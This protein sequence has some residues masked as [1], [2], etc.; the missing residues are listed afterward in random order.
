MNAPLSRSRVVVITGVTRGLGRALVD[1]FIRLGHRVFG[2]ARTS[3][4]IEALRREYPGHD[5]QSVD[6]SSDILVKNWADRIVSEH[7]PPNI[8]VNNAAVLNHR[9]NLWDIGDRDF[10]EVID[11]NIKG[12]ANTVRYFTPSM[13]SRGQGVIVNLTSRWGNYTERKM[14]P[15]CATKWAVVAISRVLA[16][17]L[18]PSGVA[19]V[20]LNPGV[21]KTAM[22]DRYLGEDDP[23][24]TSPYP[25]PA[26]WA[27]CAVPL[28]LSLRLKDTGKFRKAAVPSRSGLQ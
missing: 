1:E 24:A 28:I 5:F 7:C 4:Q 26:E 15:Y 6:V 8:L 22:L 19:V 16:E 18:K 11:V 13:I 21:V 17:E 27:K 23:L 9:A 20:G 25:A 14:A 2:C 12:I 10:S 3:D